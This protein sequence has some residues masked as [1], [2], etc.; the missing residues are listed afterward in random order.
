MN[1]F[2]TRIIKKLEEKNALAPCPRC[3]VDQFSLAQTAFSITENSGGWL[4]VEI[5]CALLVCKNCG[6]LIFHSV[7]ILDAETKYDVSTNIFTK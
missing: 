3:G 1:E 6:Y 4:G 5:P 2:Q 7:D